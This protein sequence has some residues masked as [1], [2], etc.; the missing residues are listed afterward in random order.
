MIDSSLKEQVVKMI[1]YLLL[2][3]GGSNGDDAGEYGEAAAWEA[4]R[5]GYWAHR[6]AFLYNSN[7]GVCLKE[8]KIPINVMR[9][10]EMILN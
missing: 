2:P 1:F 3:N 10:K 9:I 7:R 5:T 4:P 6:T 8:E